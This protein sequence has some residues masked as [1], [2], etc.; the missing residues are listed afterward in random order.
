MTGHRALRILAAT[1]TAVAV[2]AGASAQGITI[3]TNPQGSIYYSVG[4][5]LAAVLADTLERR[6]IVQPYAGSS[7]YLPLI[8]SGEVTMGLSSS[9][10]SGRAFS[11]ADGGEAIPELRALARLWPLSYAFIA[12]D[13]SGMTSVADLEGRRV[14][15]A[16]EA[17]A[18]LG[19]ANL[20]MLAAAGLDEDDVEGVTVGGLPQGLQGV[21]DGAIDAHG[22]AVGI[23]LTVQAD[24]AVS[25]GMRYLS[26]EGPNA[27]SEFLDEQVAGLYLQTLEPSERRPGLKQT[28]NVGAFDVFL[29]GSANLSDEEVTAILSA[30][31]DNWGRLQED[32]P[33]LRQAEMGELSRPSNTTPYHPAAVAFFTERGMWTQA[34]DERQALYGG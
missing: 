6:A 30:I 11:G 9:L 22:I 5:G 34:N 3:G 7:T 32:Y 29:M 26:I 12:R 10:D 23:P 33:V 28:T 31:A 18:A 4:G 16:I 21:I 17:N 15:T 19:A 1:A 13:D 8:A 27:T 20:A 14:V 25:G 24:A 2:A